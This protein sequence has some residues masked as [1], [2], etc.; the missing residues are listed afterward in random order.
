MSIYRQIFSFFRKFT[1]RKISP[2]GINIERYFGKT[3]E[4]YKEKKIS[5]WHSDKTAL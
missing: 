5:L 1:P 4:L 2:E 3:V